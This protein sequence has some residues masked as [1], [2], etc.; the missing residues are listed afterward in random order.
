[1]DIKKLMI[2]LLITSVF[3]LMSKQ[4][5]SAAQQTSAN[6]GGVQITYEVVG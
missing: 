3:L 4:K 5:A 2:P 6:F 1:M